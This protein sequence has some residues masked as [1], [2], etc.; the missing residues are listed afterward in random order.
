[1]GKGAGLFWTGLL[2]TAHWPYDP[3]ENWKNLN[4]TP[5]HV[6]GRHFL[7]EEPP[8]GVAEHLVFRRV[9]RRECRH[10]PFSLSLYM[11]G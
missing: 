10:R 1:L 6:E 8:A 7:L 4:C 11:L 9:M 5:L 3:G 2:R